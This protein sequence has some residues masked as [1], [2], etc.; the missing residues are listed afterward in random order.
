MPE[1]VLV[2]DDD[3]STVQLVAVTLSRAGY[4][5]LTARSGEEALSVMRYEPPNLMVLDLMLPGMDGFDVCREVRRTSSLPILIL[6]ARTDEIDRVVA[7]EIGADDYVMKPFS[8]RELAERI[9]AILRRSRSVGP[10]PV[11]DHVLRFGS[12]SMNL[13]SYEVTLGGAAV[14]LT[15]TEFQLLKVLTSSPG[16][17]FSRHE[18]VSRILRNGQTGAAR[19]LD[20][21]IYHLRTKLQGDPLQRSVIETVRGAGYRF[22][23]A[24]THGRT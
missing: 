18:L 2:V 8:P 16:R 12:L 23:A 21:H 10:A 3:E 19:T 5:V 6:T 15:P 17:V 11:E 4:E 7:F 20:V 22:S 14:S 1:R 9:K 24:R 13:V